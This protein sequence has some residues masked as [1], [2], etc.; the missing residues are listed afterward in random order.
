MS[1]RRLKLNLSHIDGK[2][3]SNRPSSRTDQLVEA[4]FSSDI[5]PIIDTQPRASSSLNT[6]PSIS[7]LR[8]ILAKTSEKLSVYTGKQDSS[9]I[10]NDINELKQKIRNLES[11]K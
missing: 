5:S 8:E 3:N 10:Y 1:G 9:S 2:S 7:K 11:E 6:M 4:S